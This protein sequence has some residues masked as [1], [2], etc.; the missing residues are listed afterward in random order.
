MRIVID[1]QGVQTASRFRGIGRYASALTHGI[2]RNAGDHEVWLVLNGALEDSITAIRADFDGLLP[3]ERIRVF[4]TPGRIAEV[5]TRAAPRC[6]AAEMMRE[7]FIALLQPDVVLVTSLFEGYDDDAVGSVGTFVDGVRTAVILYD[8]I[9]L[10]NAEAYLGSSPVRQWYMRKIDSLK[11]AGLLLAISDYAREEAIGVLGLVPDQVVAISTAVDERFAPAEPEP[12]ALAALRQRFDISRSLVMCAPGGNDERKNLMGLVTAYSLLPAPL[13]AGH[14]LLIASGLADSHRRQLLDHARH[15]GM[16][17]DELILT[18]YVSD[19]TLIALYR[20]AT[21]FVFPSLHEGFGLP[22]LEAM[23]CGTAVIGS[24]S[25]SIP[26]VIGLDEAMFDPAHPQSIA[27]K[28][29]EVLHDPALRKRL[30]EHG[31][32]QAARFS[33]DRTARRALRALEAQVAATSPSAPRDR[34]ALLTALTGVPDLADTEATML[35]L[36]LCLAALPDLAA[37]RQLLVDAGPVA[38]A[39]AAS[40]SA[41]C[42]E[43]ELLSTLLR[44]PPQGVRVVPVLLSSQGGVWHYRQ[45]LAYTARLLSLPDECGPDRVADLRTG[46]VLF[47]MHPRPDDISAGAAD[48]LWAHLQRLGVHMHFVFED[49]LAEVSLQPDM[50]QRG[51]TDWLDALQTHADGIHCS[52]PAAM[53]AWKKCQVGQQ[54]ARAGCSAMP[55]CP[56]GELPG[57]AHYRD[58]I[59]QLLYRQHGT[60]LS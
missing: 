18:G 49:A 14:Q 29:A 24:N 54:P 27:D 17:A 39:H 11:R 3:Q 25:T 33:W 12:E 7:Q 21:L 9:P 34:S 26:E 8:L 30:R 57:L 16:A 38:R 10:L 13:R 6:R 32:A 36:A 46:D 45:A 43:N 41:G 22:A 48:G 37:S 47:S 19:E 58:R 2:L 20:A 53:M 31:L 28:I 42:M 15:R 44:N 59:L 60:G 23:A 50:Q 40:G 51:Q 5:D 35:Q 56:A 1:L 52:S 4:E 55:L